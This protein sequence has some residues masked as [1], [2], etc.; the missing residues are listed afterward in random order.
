MSKTN[1]DAGI[2]VLTEIIEGGAAIEL[3][4]GMSV[5]PSIETRTRAVAKASE[6][7]KIAYAAQR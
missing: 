1:L 2:P 4:P 7:S 3:R 6:T 5:I